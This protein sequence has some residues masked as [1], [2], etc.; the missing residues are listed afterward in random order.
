[1]IENID[2]NFGKLLPKLKAW[3]I[4]EHP[5]VVAQLRAA[6]DQLWNEVPAELE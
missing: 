1:M 2:T 4:T 5:K 3:G 6:D